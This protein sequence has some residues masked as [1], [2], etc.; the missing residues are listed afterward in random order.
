MLEKRRGLKIETGTKPEKANTSSEQGI[1]YSISLNDEHFARLYLNHEALS[2]SWNGRLEFSS[3]LLNF[4]KLTQRFDQCRW[5]RPESV[6]LQWVAS[7]ASLHKQAINYYGPDTKSL[8]TIA[9]NDVDFL[10]LD[11]NRGEH[12]SLSLTADNPS[13]TSDPEIGVLVNKDMASWS[14]LRDLFRWSIYHS[15]H[16]DQLK[17]LG[18]QT[19]DIARQVTLL[20][21][22]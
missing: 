9:G 14:M 20:I 12:C 19:D 11:M 8:F 1:F 16:R 3:V 18:I 15:N 10:R 2:L 6:Y 21:R 22:Q 5:D 4:F 7:D 17:S 13:V